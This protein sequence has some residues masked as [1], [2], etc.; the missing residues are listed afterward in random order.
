MHAL[1]FVILAKHVVHVASGG[2]VW[3]VGSVE[4]SYSTQTAAL[5]VT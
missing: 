1:K 4:S 3:P 2:S 5:D